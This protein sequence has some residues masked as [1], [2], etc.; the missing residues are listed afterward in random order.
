MSSDFIVR[1]AHW[2]RES[3][4]LMA[5]REQVFI[6]EQQVPREIEMD[7]LDEQAVH[8]VVE[9]GG[10]PIAYGRLLPD[11]RIGRMAVLPEH[12]GQGLGRK[13]LDK[14]IELARGRGMERVYLH[15]QT[16]ALAFYQRAGFVE[17][18]P[19]FREAGIDHVAMQL[20]LL[21]L[22]PGFITGVAY[23]TPFDALAV[24]LAESAARHIR[25]LSPQL[26]HAVFDNRELADALSRLARRGRESLVR[27]LVSDS[28]P[29]VHRGHRLLE[30]AR[31]LPS[32]VKLQ[33]LAEHPEWKGETI[34]TRDTDGVLYKPGDA[35]HAA[36]Y[37]P[38]SR[39]STRRHVE[40]FEELWR[41][42]APDVEFR[43]M[44]L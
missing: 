33:K 39:A 5:L 1:E 44:S 16:H 27:I 17:D 37:E 21:E 41:H 14:L 13:V 32:K 25:I 42:S 3:A 4:G 9:A 43:S 12:R 30:L 8:V 34:V 2:Q 20:P 28:R 10:K 29:V 19:A 31:R 6:R 11:G 26:D 38:A 36:F 18:G 7:G 23:P 22:S 24:E 15:A 40:L 35:D